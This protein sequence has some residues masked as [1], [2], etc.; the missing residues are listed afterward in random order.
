MLVKRWI[1]NQ[2]PI[3]KKQQ[4]LTNQKKIA[5]ILLLL[6]CRSQHIKKKETP[7]K[8][9]LIIQQISTVHT[10]S[11]KLE[12]KLH[13]FFTYF[14]ARYNSIDKSS[15]PEVFCKKGVLRNFTRFK[16]KHQKF[17]SSNRRCSIN[18]GVLKNF[19]KFKGKHLC[20][21]LF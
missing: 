13:L 14:K 8:I 2:Q 11:R 7:S 20:Q 9:R 15:D 10:Q 1:D 3:R 21:S 12:I 17:K 19:A 5:I 18:K 16:G 4:E 6:S